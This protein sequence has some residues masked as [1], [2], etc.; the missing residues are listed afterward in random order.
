M[1]WHVEAEFVGELRQEQLEQAA[2]GASLAHYQAGNGVLRLRGLLLDTDGTYADAVRKAADWVGR[3][4]AVT[5]LV[6]AGVLAGP[7][8]VL[9][10][11]AAARAR[12]WD[13]VGSAEIAQRLGVSTARV[14]QLEVR[15]D[16]PAPVRELAGGRI[17]L[18]ADIEQFAAGWQRR[19]GRPAAEPA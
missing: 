9:V 14:R 6:P 13:L 17:Y 11:T 16:W 19:P 18:A 15:P 7:E 2:G 5:E 1:D 3:L 4:T 12:D 8:R 10:E